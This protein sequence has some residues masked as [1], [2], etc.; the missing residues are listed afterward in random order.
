MTITLYEPYSHHV[1]LWLGSG[2]EALGD[3]F[4]PQPGEGKSEREAGERSPVGSRNSESLQ[5]SPILLTSPKSVKYQNSH[6]TSCKASRCRLLQIQV[7]ETE[8][9]L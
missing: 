5:L 7:G 2:P 3:A 9:M 8:V 4:T 1:A 6:E